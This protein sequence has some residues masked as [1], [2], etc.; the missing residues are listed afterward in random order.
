MVFDCHTHLAE[1]EHISGSFLSDAQ[2]A[3]GSDFRLACTPKEHREAMKSCSGAI[4]LALDAPYIGFNVP[5]EYVAEYVA[6]DPSRLFGFASVDPNRIGAD[7]LLESAVK[8]LGLK[9]LKL[10]PIYQN[11]HPLD[12]M[13]YPVYAKAQQLKLPVMWH[14]GTSFV[15]EGPLEKS[16]PVLLDPVA[17][18]F[19][20]LKMIIAHL[21]HPWMGEAIATVRKHANLFADISA[22][23]SRPWQ[24]YRALIEA[25][26]YG[27]E[28]KLLFGTDFPFFN[29]ERTITALMGLNGMLEGTNYPRIPERVIDKILNKNIPEAL[30]LV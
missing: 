1:K 12:S 19:P 29:V 22:L 17:R 20:E 2:Q 8:E 30:G 9:G 25:V 15:R 21:G 18:S 27:I 16:M 10:A 26:E 13:A 14:Q 3:W 5:N 7:R 6:E 4:I 11:F 24:M 23:G 28:D